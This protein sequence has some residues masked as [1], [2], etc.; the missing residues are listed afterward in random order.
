MNILKTEDPTPYGEPPPPPK[1]LLISVGGSPAPIVFSIKQHKP[2]KIVF[3]ASAGS[4]HIV[5]DTVLP[6]LF[7]TIARILE[8]EFII[9]PNEEDIGA[10]TFELLHQMPEALRKLNVQDLVWPNFVDYTGGTKTMSAAMVWA[11]S[12]YSCHFSYIGSQAPGDR[13]KGGLGVVLDNRERWFLTENPWNKVAYFD[14]WAILHL[15]NSGQYGNA[16]A[17]LESVQKRVDL[18]QVKHVFDVL[19]KAFQGY[20]QWDIFNHKEAKACLNRIRDPL[21]GLMHMANPPIAGLREFA[22]DTIDLFE[23]L[24]GIEQGSLSM[25]WDLLANA[26]RRAELESKYDDAVARCYSAIEKAARYRLVNQYAINPSHAEPEKIPEELRDEFIRRHT[27]EYQDK[28]GNV[29]ER[30]RFGLGD[31]YR[32]LNALGDPLGQRYMVCQD[33]MKAALES[34][35]CSILAHGDVPVIKK[36]FNEL[37][38]VAVFLLKLETENLTKFPVFKGPLITHA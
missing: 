35:N 12:R 26:L 32:L 37:F 27:F 25:V 21:A 23:V 24:K 14:V 15:F 34:R 28:K 31:A 38:N 20:H 16:A 1:L 29:L 18:P 9:T 5:T 8:H 4:R 10:S 3:F 2:D 7:K 13:D 36:S 11:S 19:F 17:R 30:L 22:K 6:E 33:K